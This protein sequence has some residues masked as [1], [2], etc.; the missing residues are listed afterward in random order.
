MMCSNGLIGTQSSGGTGF[1]PAGSLKGGRM[2]V[3]NIVS[4][5]ITGLNA[6]DGRFFCF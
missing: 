5:L 4:V 6:Y 2:S 3:N 1:F